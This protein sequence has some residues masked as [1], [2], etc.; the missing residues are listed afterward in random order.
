MCLCAYV[1]A[2]A[3]SQTCRGDLNSKEKE[4]GTVSCVSECAC[5]LSLYRFNFN[6]C[7]GMCLCVY[8][9]VILICVF[10]F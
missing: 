8:L 5:V 3:C 2:C 10:V 9:C 6:I 1:C 7:P 4:A